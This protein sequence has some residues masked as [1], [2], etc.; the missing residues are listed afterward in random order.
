MLEIEIQHGD[1]TKVKAD[2]I[3]YPSNSFAWMGGTSA[4]TIKS[5][6]GKIIE[7]SARAK[8]PLEVGKPIATTSGD[9]PYKAVIHAPTMEMPIG[10][11]LEYN[12]A[13]SVRGALNFADDAEYKTIAMPGMGTGIGSFPKEEAAEIMIEEIKK[14]NPI[15]LEKVILIDIDE[16]MVEAWKKELK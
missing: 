13:L 5:E 16:K 14:F 10:K 12:V 2:A 6:G 9:L 4:R 1:I 7:D 8:A 11:A 15:N 3:V